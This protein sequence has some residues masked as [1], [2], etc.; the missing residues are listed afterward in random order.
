M[1][2]KIGRVFVVHNASG[3]VLALIP[4]EVQPRGDGLQVGIRPLPGPD[5][6]VSEAEL[7]SEC[8]NTPLNQLV[9]DFEVHFDLT[10]TCLRVTRLR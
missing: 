6:F 4:A 10:S 1:N 8:I 7:P 9:R 2:T 3:N 5:Q